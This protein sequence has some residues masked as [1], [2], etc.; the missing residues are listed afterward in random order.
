[1]E[2]AKGIKVKTVKT[3]YGDIIKLGINVEAIKA[4]PINGEWLNVD[5]KQ[6]KE[7]KEWYAALDEYKKG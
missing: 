2:F 4:N 6:S 1:M 3:Q 5:L 7:T